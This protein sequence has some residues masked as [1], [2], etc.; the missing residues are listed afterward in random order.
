MHVQRTLLGLVIAGVAVMSGALPAAQNRPT[1]PPPVRAAAGGAAAVG[2][3]TITGVVVV[4]GTGVPARRSRV[5]ITSQEA[6]MT[7]NTV[8]DE[9]GR[10]AFSNLPAGRYSLTAAKPG[11]IASSYGQS[12]P[13]LPG[14]PIQLDDGQKFEAR[15]QITRGGVLTGVVLDE[16]GDAI[17]GIQVRALRYVRQNGQRTLRGENIASTD[18]RGIYRIFGLQ[19]GDYLLAATA[20]NTGDVPNPEAMRAQ[21]QT[22]R[23]RAAALGQSDMPRAD[24][25]IARLEEIQAAA[26]SDGAAPATGYAP[27]YYPGTVALAQAGAVTLGPGEE[28]AGLDFQ[29]QR[30]AVARVEGLV[31][32]ATG[33]AAQNIQVT[34]SEINQPAP[35]VGNS[36]ARVDNE[37]RFRFSNVAPG[38]YRIAA[39][40]IVGGGRGRGAVESGPFAGGAGRRGMVPAG[41]DTLRLWAAAEI[42]V[43][44]RN[45]NDIALALQPG[46]SASGRIVFQ[47]SLPPPADLTQIRVNVIPADA[48]PARELSAPVVG[49]VDPS[50]K[51]TI[52][53]ITPG[54]YRLNA[55][56]AERGWVLDAAVVDGQDSLDFPFEIKSE[57]V[58]AAVITFTDRRSELS[59]AL[60]DERGQPALGYTIVLFPADERFRTPDS[61]RI[62]T[63]RPGTDGRFMFGVVP[64]GDYKLAPVVDVE[65]GS[66]YD[67]TFLEQLDITALRVSIADGEQ[68][69]QNM[70][71]AGG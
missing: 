32:T 28:R 40:G 70:R 21:V 29:L 12:R 51:F 43:D 23:D 46:V 52:D 9:N 55:S 25:F 6:R 41:A 60:T 35:G 62:R 64:P 22:F 50:G 26:A 42:S 8:A 15:L 66:W 47:G 3:A 5:T 7:R 34:L 65:P 33:Q 10:F 69:I 48:G 38:R 2:T 44:G 1:A 54:R 58:G 13:G 31:V 20:R 39:R 53:G 36:S 61:R 16:D 59:G 18:D 56:G 24:A 27:I 63:A 45:I 49:R 37:G 17:P 11:H 67:P 68:K 19:P 30:V 57:N 14:T 71:V 4:S